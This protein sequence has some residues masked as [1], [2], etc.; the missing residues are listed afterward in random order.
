MTEY[1]TNFILLFKMIIITQALSTRAELF[2]AL[3]EIV[4]ERGKKG[5]K[6]A[7]QV[8]AI[9]GLV[10]KA[11]RFGPAPHIK[12]VVELIVALLDTNRNKKVATAMQQGLWTEC[13]DSLN[14]IA[15]LLT[16][17]AE[18]KRLPI[19]L[20]YVTTTDELLEDDDGTGPALTVK[21]GAEWNG[22]TVVN[23]CGPKIDLVRFLC[24]CNFHSII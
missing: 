22:F 3:A 23:I 7:E 9:R 4:A 18:S 2:E 17:G 5:T 6:A 24:M 10:S 20:R 15:R 16:P 8:D 13:V 12:L 1:F 11:A 21:E 19:F 14:L